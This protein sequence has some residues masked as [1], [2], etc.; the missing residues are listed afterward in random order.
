MNAATH[1]RSRQPHPAS[2]TDHHRDLCDAYRMTILGGVEASFIL[3]EG[4]QEALEGRSGETADTERF[5]QALNV[6]YREM[7][8]ASTGLEALHSSRGVA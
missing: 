1:L 2:V 5:M 8:T 3:L 7:A 6:A 4:I